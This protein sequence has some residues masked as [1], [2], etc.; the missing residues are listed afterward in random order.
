MSS[1]WVRPTKLSWLALGLAAMH[2]LPAR[3]HLGDFLVAPSV[4]DA[5]KGFGAALAVLVLMLPTGVQARLAR[6]LWKHRVAG[7]VMSSALAV[8]H[9]VPATDHVPKLLVHIT[10]GDGWRAVGSSVA[11]VWFVLPRGMQLEVV[12]VLARVAKGNVVAFRHGTK[13]DNRS[14]SPRTASASAEA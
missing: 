14:F 5:W 8:A 9:L 10:W 3:H 4:G 12:R 6:M 7:V 1:K 13:R 2:L 11:V